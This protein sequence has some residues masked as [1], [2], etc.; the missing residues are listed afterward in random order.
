MMNLAGIEEESEEAVAA[1]TA[2]REAYFLEFASQMRQVVSVP[3]MVTGGFRTAAAMSS[4]VADDRIDL[5]GLARPLCADPGAPRRILEEGV[6]LESPEDRLRLGPG[7]LGP[8]SPILMLKTIN[9]LGVMSW[10]YQQIRRIGAGREPDL[11]MRVLPAFLREQWAQA[12][13]LWAL[14]H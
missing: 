14:R 4:A 5:I 3:L 10:Y 9:G 7:W 8:G 6:D 1:S 12:K 2:S 11:G 13:Y